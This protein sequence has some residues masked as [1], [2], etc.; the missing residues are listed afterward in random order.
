MNQ[1]SSICFTNFTLLKSIM[2]RL[3]VFLV[4]YCGSSYNAVAET[5]EL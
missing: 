5:Y 4:E 2:E 1:L 3:K